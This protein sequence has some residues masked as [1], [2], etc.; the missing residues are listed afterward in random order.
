MS[1]DLEQEYFADGIVEDITSALSRI[2]WLFVISRNS[3]FTYKGRAVN[4]GQVGRCETIEAFVAF[5]LRSLPPNPGADDRC[6]SFGQS[7]AKRNPCMCNRFTS[8]DDGELRHTIKHRELA[9]IKISTRIEIL[10]LGN[11][12]WAKYSVGIIVAS[13]MPETPRDRFDQ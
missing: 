9:I 10:D 1:D 3:S 6:G 4:V 8:G 7:V 12:L 13:A 11:D 5:V 2:K